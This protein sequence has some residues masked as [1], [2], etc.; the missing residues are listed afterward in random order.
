MSEYLFSVIDYCYVLLFFHL[1]T[2]KKIEKVK[3]IIAVVIFSSIQ[4][5]SEFVELPRMYASLKDNFL[6]MFFFDCIF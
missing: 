4:Y 5:V 6:L 1:L 2:N 3:F